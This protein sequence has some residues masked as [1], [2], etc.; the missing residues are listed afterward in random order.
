[1]DRIALITTTDGLDAE[2]RSAYERIAESRG[3]VTRPFQVLLHTPAMALRV[4]ELGHVVRFESHL[5]D[6]DRELVTLAT[7]QALGCS[8]VWESHLR[9]AI[10]AGVAPA[11]V[12]ALEGDRGGLG[13]RESVLVAFVDELCGPGT[14]S[15]ATFAA[16][17]ALLDARGTVELALTVAYYTMLARIMGA[18]GAC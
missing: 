17:H 15:D 3:E 2:A 7:G 6:A 1:M 4:A 18:C 16:A 14:V 11:T 13:G 10:A 8:F 5:P 9:S 12:S